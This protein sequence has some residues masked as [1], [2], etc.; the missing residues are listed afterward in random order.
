MQVT[1]EQVALMV[2]TLA[3]LFNRELSS[4]VFQAYWIGLSDLPSDAL[5]RSVAAAVRTC[6]FMPT[7]S[8]LRSLASDRPNATPEDLA[9]V[10]FSAVSNA[11]GR[12]GSYKSV[13]F[14]D[15]VVNAT[16][17]TLGGWPEICSKPESE[18]NTFFRNDFIKQYAAFYRAGV[19]G[20]I[21]A[22]LIGLTDQANLIGGYNQ[23]KLKLIPCGTASQTVRL[24]D[25]RPRDGNG[26]VRLEHKPGSRD[27]GPEKTIRSILEDGALA[28]DSSGTPKTQSVV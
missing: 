4:A 15:P 1:K 26:S 18:F 20:E 22:P 28:S 5:E 23:S 19:N 27:G 9:M 6:K 16:I 25:G 3:E 17:R 7:P 2:T 24:I 21:T 13:S 8:E 10:A 12:I 14:D 11:V